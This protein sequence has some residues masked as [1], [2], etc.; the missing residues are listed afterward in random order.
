[1][2]RGQALYDELDDAVQLAFIVLERGEMARQEGDLAQVRQLFEQS[3]ALHRRL[4]DQCM[5]PTALAYLAMVLIHFKEFD[6]AREFI[7]ECWSIGQM[8]RVTKEMVP[9]VT[10]FLANA[11]G[12]P[13]RAAHLLGLH[14]ALRTAFGTHIDIGERPDYD[15]NLA[16]LRLK[17]GD[18]AF[19]AAWAEGQ[20]L[21]R[22]QAIDMALRNEKNQS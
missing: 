20:T 3:V 1:M 8:K 11:Q 6:R 4:K 18:R 13:D 17:L 14:G 19:K 10:A 15:R 2:E 21:T 22:E 16:E 9:M 12:Q 7:R 5:L